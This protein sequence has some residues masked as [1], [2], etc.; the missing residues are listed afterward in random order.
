MNL[1]THIA[2]ALVVGTLLYHDPSVAVLVG[3]GAALPDLDREYVFTSRRVFARFQIHRALFHN[4]FFAL[5][6]LMFNY[7]VGLGVLLHIALDLL[8]SPTDRGVELFFPLGRFVKKYKLSYRGGIKE[9]GK[10][11]MWYLE[12]PLPLIRRTAD[13][14]LKEEKGFPWLRVYGP[15]KNSRI[16]DWGIFYTSVVFLVFLMGLPG[17]LTWFSEVLRVAFTKYTFVSVGTVLFYG[18]GEAWRRRVQ[19][20][21]V[22]GLTKVS[23]AGTMTLD[24]G[25]MIYGGEKLIHPFKLIIPQQDVEFL[26]IS[27]II[28][29]ILSIIHV[30]FRQG[31]LVL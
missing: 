1:N 6:T 24:I 5:G 18:I 27:A 10:G 14:G 26:F 17:F 8:T 29:L 7:Y 13:P 21:N 19:F 11:L 15:F 2:A 12:D 25:L 20:L 9:P 3:I 23:V 22:S 16:V 28:G 31:E 4:I 30:K